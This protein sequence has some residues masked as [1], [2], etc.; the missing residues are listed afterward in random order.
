MTGMHWDDGSV[1]LYSIA[2]GR[3]TI[4]SGDYSTAIGAGTTASG[5]YSTAMGDSTAASGDYSTAMGRDTTAS[6]IVSTSMGYCTTAQSFAS[7]VIGQFNTVSGSAGSW[8][9]ADPVFVI[10]N[11]TSVAAPSDAFVVYKNGSISSSTGASLTAGGTWTNSSDRN[12]KENFEEVNTREILSALVN[13]PVET[14]N[15]KTQED[16]IRH[17]GPMAQD[18]YSA[19]KVGENDKTITTVDADGVA[20]AAIQGLNSIVEEQ[21]AVIAQ[22]QATIDN[23]K[24]RLE[25]LEAKI[26]K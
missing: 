2:T 21:K 8:V 14:W 11:G 24:A 18:F 10:G 25:S 19:F 1:G 13:I 22:Q 12:A 23:L 26:G 4:A 3:D 16:S 20:L 6:G 9:A 5:D 7:L 17:I 15:Y